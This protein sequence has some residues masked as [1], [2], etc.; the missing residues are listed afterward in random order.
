MY[1]PLRWTGRI[2]AGLLL[3]LGLAVLG[4]Y[5]TSA[6]KSSRT[7]EVEVRDVPIPADSAA[8]VRGCGDSNGSALAG[9]PQLRRNALVAARRHQPDDRRGIDGPL[10]RSADRGAD[11]P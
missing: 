10:E 4:L 5:A 1:R 8:F 11:G 7:Y 9:G 3:V 6:Y 2:L